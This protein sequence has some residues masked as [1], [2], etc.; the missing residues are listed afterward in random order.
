MFFLLFSGF[1]MNLEFL[2]FLILI[3]H[4]INKIYRANV[5]IKRLVCICCLIKI[6]WKLL[7]STVVRKNCVL[8]E[9]VLNPKWI[10]IRFLVWSYSK[11]LDIKSSSSHVMFWFSALNDVFY[12][13]GYNFLQEFVHVGKNLRK[14]F[15]RIWSQISNPSQIMNSSWKLLNWNNTGES[16]KSFFFVFV[17]LA[18]V[19]SNDNGKKHFEVE[20]LE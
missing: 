18:N 15:R 8:V 5:E 1:L 11:I 4:R 7:I 16:E 6:K 3:A 13:Y 19:W 2:W 12:A 10:K 9:Q 14:H 20:Q 17:T